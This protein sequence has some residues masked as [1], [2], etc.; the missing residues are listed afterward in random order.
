ME[1]Q[2]NI[3]LLALLM[4]DPFVFALKLIPKSR[5]KLLKLVPKLLS[6]MMELKMVPR[7]L[8]GL[9]YRFNGR[10]LLPCSTRAWL[11]RGFVIGLSWAWLDRLRLR[12]SRYFNILKNKL[13]RDAIIAK[14]DE[15]DS[16]N[17]TNVTN[18]IC[19]TYRASVTFLLYTY[20][21]FSSQ[22]NCRTPD[23]QS[24]LV[25]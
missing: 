20:M 15:A 5:T 24:S 17:L 12:S 13:I 11:G 3:N 21:S 19:V 14:L 1:R 4:K 6:K 8:V 9:A 18:I 7:L 25:Y 22:Y 23:W 10:L 2:Y 16:L